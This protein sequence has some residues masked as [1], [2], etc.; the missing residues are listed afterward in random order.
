MTNSVLTHRET[1]CKCQ[2]AESIPQ[3]PSP[4]RRT[5]KIQTLSN[6]F[7]PPTSMTLCPLAV[8]SLMHSFV[9]VQFRLKSFQSPACQRTSLRTP[10]ETSEIQP[11]VCSAATSC[12]SLDSVRS[13]ILPMYNAGGS[14]N[15]KRIPGLSAQTSTSLLALLA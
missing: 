14:M 1:S 2:H 6:F 8:A 13:K 9:S 12:T 10:C 15:G 3:D 11:R 4:S 5:G 7:F